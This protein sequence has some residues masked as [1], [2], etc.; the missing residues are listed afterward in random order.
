MYIY[1]HAEVE[2]KQT[3]RPTTLVELATNKH[4]HRQ[5]QRESR[6]VR[7]L[8]LVLAETETNGSN[9]KWPSGTKQAN[10]Q[11]M[12]TRILHST[13]TVPFRLTAKCHLVDSSW[14]SWAVADAPLDA[15]AASPVHSIFRERCFRVRKGSGSALLVGLVSHPPS[16]RDT[17]IVNHECICSRQV[18]RPFEIGTHNCR[19][20][21]R[22][23]EPP[24][25]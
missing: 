11:K 1:S 25:I 6:R 22:C 3:W 23:V 4:S 16:R 13:Q 7:T 12:R 18:P 14:W 20:W 10:K 17:L 21:R 15:R 19:K 5:G 24:R 8:G 9:Q 2:S